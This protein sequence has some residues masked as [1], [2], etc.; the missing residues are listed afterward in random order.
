[1]WHPENL[2]N[3]DIGNTSI[4]IVH[5]FLMKVVANTALKSKDPIPTT[6]QRPHLF[7]PYLFS[8]IGY[9]LIPISHI[10]PNDFSYSFPYPLNDS[11]TTM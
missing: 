3:C 7:S 8:L 2:I 5:D 9:N 10:S 4:A 11:C 6:Y 1:V